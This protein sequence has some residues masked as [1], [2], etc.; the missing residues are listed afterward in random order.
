MAELRVRDVAIPCPTNVTSC[1]QKPEAGGRFELKQSMVQL[2]HAN[3]QFT[4]LPH[5]DPTVHIQN[6]LEISDTYTPAGVNV[7]YV[8]LTL[9]PFSLLGEAKR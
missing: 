5:E 7:D 6:F 8:R 3:G 9:F 1:I 4:G 2:L